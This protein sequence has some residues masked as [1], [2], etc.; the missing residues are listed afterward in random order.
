MSGRHTHT[1]VVCAYKESPYLEEC[2][3]SL[4]AQ[5]VKSNIIIVTSTPN[6]YIENMAKKY[7][8]PYRINK[9]EGGITQDWNFGYAQADS[10]YVTIAHQDDVYKKEYLSEALA[11]M[12]KAKHPLIFFSDYCEI[13]DGKDIEKNKLLKIKRFM[14]LPLRIKVLQKS[15]WVRR[16]I[17]SLGSPICCPSVAFAVENLPKVIFRNGFRACEDW[18]AWEMLSKLPGEFLYSSKILM[19]HRIHAESETSAI[20]GDNM[21]SS[22]EY[23]MFCKFWP[24]KIA[25][26]LTK[27][28]AGGQKSNQLD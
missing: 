22:E 6:D 25:K 7:G 4:K 5:T 24:K 3:L 23:T 2:I 15:R 12:K 19:G 17:L 26:V 20:I 9:G 27:L 10:K 18:E 28:Y 21:R 11:M 8:L 14:L 16:R 13:R 1:F